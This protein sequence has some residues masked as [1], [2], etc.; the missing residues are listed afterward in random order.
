MTT[1]AAIVRTTLDY[2]TVQRTI[3]STVYSEPKTLWH[4]SCYRLHNLRAPLVCGR[5][6]TGFPSGSRSS[7]KWPQSLS[8]RNLGQPAYLHDLLQEYQ[9]TRTLRSSTAHLLHQPY[10][11][12]SVSSRA[13]SVAAP[14]IWNQLTVNMRTASTLGTYK[15]RLKTKLFTLA[16]PT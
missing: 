10:A 16:Y 2:C 3:T 5:S 13:F 1:A 4:M 14:T 15:T 9:P 8:K 6:C 11:S 12:T 7:L